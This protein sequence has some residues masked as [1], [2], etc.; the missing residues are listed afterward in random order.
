MDL[1][2]LRAVVPAL[3]VPR[4]ASAPGPAPCAAEGSSAATEVWRI[5]TS[6]HD[7]GTGWVGGGK[8]QV[9]T[10]ALRPAEAGGVCHQRAGRRGPRGLRERKSSVQHIQICP[11]HRWED[12]ARQNASSSSCPADR[13]RESSLSFQQGGPGGP[14]RYRDTQIHRWQLRYPGRVAGGQGAQTHREREEGQRGPLQRGEA[15]GSAHA[16]FNSGISAGRE[17]RKAQW[18]PC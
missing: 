16:S 5:A 4:R 3:K 18:L 15:R 13:W 2:L 8:A 1:L 10:A 11:R 6:L 9:N 12:R 14:Q 7:R 17:D